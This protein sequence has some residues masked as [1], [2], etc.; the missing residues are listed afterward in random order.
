MPRRGENIYKRKDGRWEG[1]FKPCGFSQKYKYVYAPT[2]KDVKEKLIELKL[3]DSS[4]NDKQ[5]LLCE[6]CNEWLEF[7][8]EDIKESTYIKYRNII[9][10]QINPHIGNAYLSRLRNEDMEK[11]ILYLKNR[12][13]SNKSIRD[14]LSVVAAIVKYAAKKGLNTNN[15]YIENL[16]PKTE[17]RQ[18]KILSADE[19]IRL[20]QRIIKS[21]NP[22]EYGILLALYSGMRIGEIC[23]LKWDNI[24]LNA[25][26]ISVCQTLQRLQDKENK[27]KTKILISEPKSQSSKRIIPTPTFL[28]K[29]LN[30]I[31]PSSPCAFFLTGG[32]NFMEPRTLDN[33]YKKCLSECEIKRIN[34]HALRHT[35][36]TRC[37]EA[38]FDIKSLSEILGH[39]N[40]STTLNLY[41]HPTLEHKRANMNKLV[42]F[43]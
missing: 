15:L 11:F 40:V 19:R 35:F 34:F 28:T 27:G 20:E 29:L 17:K 41:A 31:K 2:Y 42:P 14:V 32:E 26:T 9:L 30:Q 22:A 8:K 38:G 36:A 43:E 13:L 23:A 24:D 3:N 5:I 21:K 6:L 4:E 18:I 10:N 37:V 16:Y 39:S 25:G 1:R 12:G 7:K 33:I